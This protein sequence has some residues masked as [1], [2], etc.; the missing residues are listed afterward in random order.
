MDSA[1]AQSK[2]LELMLEGLGAGLTRGKKQ[3]LEIT[4]RRS[5]DSAAASQLPFVVSAVLYLP[6]GRTPKHTSV[7]PHCCLVASFLSP[8]CFPVDLSLAL[9]RA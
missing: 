8:K 6:F 9:Q 2:G 3:L 1:F 7:R 4:R 5:G